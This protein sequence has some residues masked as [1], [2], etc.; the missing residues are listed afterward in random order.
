MP[1]LIKDNTYAEM[2][3]TSQKI[4]EADDRTAVA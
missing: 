3:S 4:H 1:P 2:M